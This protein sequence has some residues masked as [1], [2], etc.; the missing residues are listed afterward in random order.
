MR[1]ERKPLQ[2]RIALAEREPEFAPVRVVTLY[3]R[4]GCHLCDEARAAILAMRAEAAPF[5][6][7]EVDIDEDDALHAR[8]LERIPVV[9]VDGEIVSELVLEPDRVLASLDTVRP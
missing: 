2:G 3:T 7:R 5:E 4:P 9:E 8:Y 1:C 6:V